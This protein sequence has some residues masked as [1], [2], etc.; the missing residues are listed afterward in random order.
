[1]FSQTLKIILRLRKK[2]TKLPVKEANPASRTNQGL[3][4][5]KMRI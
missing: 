4:K 3:G 2:V 1:M 5:I